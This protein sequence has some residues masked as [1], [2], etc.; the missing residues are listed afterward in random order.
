[1][2]TQVLFGVFAL[3]L[4]IKVPIPFALGLSTIF[5]VAFVSER[6]LLVVVQR[7]A[8]SM[9]SFALIAVPLFVLAGE[10]MNQSGAGKRLVDF[11][12]ILIGHI[13]GGLAHANI[14][15]SMF[16]GG[17]SG[18]ASADTAA[19]GSIMIPA[20]SEGGYSKTFSTIVTISSSPIGN[21]I[22]PSIT[23]VIY[24]W[25]AG[26]PI[27]RLFMAGIV[28]G[29]LIG[30]LLMIV[31]YIISK[32]NNYGVKKDFD[33]SGF[34]ETFVSA[35]PA[36]LM[37][38]IILGGMFIGMFTATEAAA[39]AVV[40]GFFISIFVYKEPG[41]SE[42]PNIFIRACKISGSIMLLIAMTEGFGW[43]MSLEQIPLHLSLFFT[44]AT[45]TA[46]LFL[47]ATILISLIVGMFLTPTAALVL[48]VPILLPVA[49]TFIID[50]LHFG[51]V[52]VSALVVGHVTPPVGL[53]LYVGS[54]ISGIP[55][56][57]LIKPVMPF[58]ITL[59]LLSVLIAIF[60]EMVMFLPE[61]LF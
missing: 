14:I 18:A 55:I 53:C 58:F 6:P 52:L 20:M 7:M 4:L 26:I 37:P 31:S 17:I 51:L 61:L 28:P 22:P 46:T 41:L 40:Y 54:N 1:M 24:G 47:F 42:F 15:G 21:I 10:I 8:T 5:T 44:E 59:V 43:V 19:I 11:A 3:L 60:P 45:P 50:P 9:E 27:S 13:T 57:G 12:N 49:E 35:F 48:L 36:L 25:L 33:L 38:I 16:F 23:M 39:V 56:S 2:A 29:I 30:I 34:W 32:R